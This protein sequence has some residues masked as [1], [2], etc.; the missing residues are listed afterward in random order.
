MKKRLE[1]FSNWR[2]FQ[3]LNRWIQILLA[4]IFLWGVNMMANRYYVRK[5]LALE[6]RYALSAE[7][8]AYLSQ[9]TRPVDIIVTT[10]SDV[11]HPELEQA[12][13]ALKQLLKEYVHESGSWK[14][15]FVRVE[16]VNVYQQ[17][18]RAQELAHAYNLSREYAIIVASELGYRQLFP[19]DLYKA[20]KGRPKLFI[21]EQA[22]TAAII[23]VSTQSQPKL[24][25][26][27][28]HGEM[29]VED[30]NPSRGL[31]ELELLLR[32]KNYAIE[33]LNLSEVNKIP[34]DAKLV[35]SIAPQAA[36]LP[37]EEEILQ[38]YLLLR[39][40]RMIV[41]LSP[42]YPHGM[43]NLFYD[44]GILAEDLV[45]M[46]SGKDFQVAGGDFLIR[47]FAQHPITES[48]IDYQVGLLTG[49]W[50]PIQFE[51]TMP[52]DELLGMSM[53]AASSESSWAKKVSRSGL[54]A[55]YDEDDPK[56]PLP[57]G[58]AAERRIGADL[59]V[60]MPGGKLVVLGNA[61]FVSNQRLNT[62]GNHVLFLNMVRWAL[63]QHFALTIPP[64]TVDTFQVVM[65]Q[66]DFYNLALKFA[67]VP[68]LVGALGVGVYWS[69][70]RS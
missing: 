34:D 22:L 54:P 59:G 36:L 51:A 47:R 28:G 11:S 68:L 30:V 8:R 21:G 42:M 3:K 56:G 43:N 39:N 49:F 65:S 50:R 53:V 13:E 6:S 29:G 35:L 67:G 16:Y 46:D 61:D 19:G 41:L 10:G 25:F 17:K 2:R 33:Q 44:W 55:E 14:E 20:E 52:E 64:K 37:G 70:K 9:L 66:S 60:D 7:T 63:D 31:S 32:Q 27:T 23:E 26:L 5:D 18:K 4:V 38:D 57:L 58:I 45:V 1:D 48:L 40:G 12:H 69:R 15:P 24:Y 62:L